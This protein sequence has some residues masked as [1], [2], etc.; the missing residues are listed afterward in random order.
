MNTETPLP[1]TLPASPFT[2][3][4]LLKHIID[5]SEDSYDAE[6]IISALGEAESARL[7]AMH[8]PLPEPPPVIH[9]VSPWQALRSVAYAGCF[10]AAWWIYWTR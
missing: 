7:S 9:V 3:P 2:E 1:A 4:N 10:L 6:R 8:P 5:C